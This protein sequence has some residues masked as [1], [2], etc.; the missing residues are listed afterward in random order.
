MRAKSRAAWRAWLVRHH[1]TAREVTLIYARK[2]SGK[3]SVTYDESVEEALCFGWIDGVRGTVD[4]QHYCVR[5][6]PRQPASRWS[7]ANLER[8]A[9]LVQTGR[10]HPAGLAAAETGRARGLHAT[11][12]AVRDEVEPP[13]ELRA[14][15]AAD[16]AGRARFM[17]VTPGQRKAWT[18][19]VAEARTPDTRTRRAR[20]ALLLIAAGRK[21]GETDAQAAR[22][23]V[24]RKA[25]ILGRD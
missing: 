5:F 20:E 2:G 25:Q 17:A 23:G 4:A 14:V 1:A 21:A 3:P 13:D 11:A 12:Y 22:R 15:L 9:R 16:R 18:R 6:T 10:M 7:K 24:A 8:L 19:W